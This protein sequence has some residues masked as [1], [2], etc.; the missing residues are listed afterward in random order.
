MFFIVLILLVLIIVCIYFIVALIKGSVEQKRILEV[1]RKVE[2]ITNEYKLTRFNINEKAE[3]F[4]IESEF[5]NKDVV[6]TVNS[7]KESRKDTYVLYS[8]IVNDIDEILSCKGC[9]SVDE[10]YLRLIAEKDILEQLKEKAKK[11][12][13]VVESYKIEILHEERDLLFDVK[14]AFNY[15]LNSKKCKSDFV[16]IREFIV[17]DEPKDLMMF[18]YESEP[19]VL[20]FEGYYFCLFGSVI[21]VFD[22]A[23]IFS[24]AVDPC[25]LN[26]TVNRKTM[27]VSVRNGVAGTNEYVAEDSKLI[28]RGITYSTW[29][30]ACRDGSPDLRYKY[31]PRIEYR[32]DTYE[33]T[34]V[35]FIIADKKA[36]FSVSSE[37]VGE[38]FEQV[39][40]NYLR[41]C[42]YLRNSVPDLLTLLKKIAGEDDARISDIISECNSKTASDNYFCKV[43]SS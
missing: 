4:K 31:N 25:A 7:Y 37:A 34:V 29:L 41:K 21:L 40:L 19:M 17:T 23:G 18:K 9:G 39:A 5:I 15:L 22:K 13:S 11:Y 30:H 38:F 16:N 27:S 14:L 3:P 42:N 12:L 32:T 1:T 10:E 20:F 8:S 28:S 43:S 26:I 24:T 35:E 36:S 33:Y 2:G 6:L